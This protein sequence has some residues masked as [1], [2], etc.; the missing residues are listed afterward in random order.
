MARADEIL[1]RMRS[2][3]RISDPGWDIAPGTP[4]YRILEAVA[5]EIAK[6]AIDGLLHDYHFDIDRKTGQDLDSFVG[7]FGFARILGKRATGYVTFGRGTAASETVI[8]PVGTQVFANLPSGIVYFQTTTTVAMAIGETSVMAP[9]EAVVAGTQGNVPAGSITNLAQP[10]PGVTTVTNQSPTDGGTDPESDDALRDRWKRTV[11]RNMAGTEDQLL[12]VAFQSQEVKQATVIGP[13]VRYS[14]QLQVPSSSPYTVTSQVPDSKYTYPPE[15]EAV[16]RDA[17]LPTEQYGI[18]LTD[19]SFSST[20]PPTVTI[21]NT[22]KFPPSSIITLEHDY[23]PICSRNDPANAIANKVDIFVSGAVP[24]QVSETVKMNTALVFD[25]AGGSLDKDNWVRD[26]GVTTPS[27]GNYLMRL[28]KAPLYSIPDTITVSGQTY[29]KDVHYWLIRD[30]TN[31]RGSVRAADGIEWL[32]TN[33][34]ANETFVDITYMYNSL[35]ER[36]DDDINLVRLVGMD[37][38]VHEAAYRRL[39]FNL[40]LVLFPTFLVENV[41]PNIRSALDS[42]LTSKGF[43]DHVQISDVYSVIS[44]VVGVDSVRLLNSSEQRSEI[45]TVTLLATSGNFRL[46]FYGATTTDIAY[47]ATA[48]AVRTALEAL[49]TIGTGNVAVT[50]TTVTGGY[51]WTVTFQSALAN[52]PLDLLVGSSGSPPHNGT[53]TIARSQSGRGYGIQV[54]SE[55]GRGILATYTSDFYLR[56]DEI[57]TMNDVQY[58]LL[59]RN[60]F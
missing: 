2:A 34:P 10:I 54:V 17:G 33:A 36:V 1:E 45:Q 52:R 16:I 21:L 42:W 29:T 12:A 53:L 48:T 14:E 58:R 18:Y 32:S 23:T 4:E 15:N 59:A 39:R 57:A 13:E 22:S 51:T 9:I 8:I 11:F 31:L 43:R 49:P 38:L 44:N 40:G 47:N 3:L 56:S 35:V 6:T 41:V 37:T 50:R 27:V 55:N 25:N 26:D 19:Y 20:V 30:V 46:S 7:L 60:T 28:S 24:R 5:Q